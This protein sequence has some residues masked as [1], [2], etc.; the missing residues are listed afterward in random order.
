MYG[1]LLSH[2]GWIGEVIES[3]REVKVGKKG[4][5]KGEESDN[6]GNWRLHEGRG[7]KSDRNI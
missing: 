4:H 2:L 7:R 5:K 6:C 1:I 3:Q